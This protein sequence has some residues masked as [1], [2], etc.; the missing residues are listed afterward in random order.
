MLLSL[1]SSV[2]A[3]SLD[4]QEEPEISASEAAERTGESTVL[5]Q[6]EAAD[7]AAKVI[8]SEQARPSAEAVSGSTE[9]LQIIGVLSASH[10]YTTYGYIGVTADAL[11]RKAYGAEQVRE[12]MTEVSAMC[13]NVIDQLGRLNKKDLTPEDTASIAEL[14]SIY[15][16]L[17]VEAEALKSYAAQRTEKNAAEYDLARRNVWPR[18]EK[19]LG[20]KPEK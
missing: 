9:P 18:I 1:L 13:D 2:P 3:P 8:Q 15:R 10:L 11:T 6:G 17:R 20:L 12:L 16:Q 19:L 5:A 14:I 7:V 4:A